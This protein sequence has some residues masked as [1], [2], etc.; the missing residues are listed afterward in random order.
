MNT[1]M[2]YVT[3]KDGDEAR[4]IGKL[5]VQS[6]LAA[7]VNVFE[8]MHSIYEWNGELQEDLEAV[9]IAKTIEAKVPAVI[10]AVRRSHSYQIPCILALPV[11][12]GNPDF[13]DWIAQQVKVAPRDEET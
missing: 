12:D 10:E 1:F 9:M 8:Q 3:T 7:C 5:L 13:I 2:I 6:R 4:R 11:K